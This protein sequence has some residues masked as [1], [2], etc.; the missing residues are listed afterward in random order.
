MTKLL[1]SERI[2]HSLK[3]VVACLIGLLFTKFISF[4]SDIWVVVSVIVV[5]CAQ[6][7]VG[8]V[9]RKSY[10]R[11]LGTLVGCLFAVLTLLLIGTSNVAIVV[12]I[13][14]S[15]FIFSYVATS[16]ETLMY[17]GT[18]GAVTTAV[19]MLG[20]KPTVI[21]A[22]ER[23]LEISIGILIATI[24]SQFILPIHAR[25]HLRN[26]QAT[27]LEQLRDYYIAIM[28]P[29]QNLSSASHYDEI[30]DG[31]IKLLSKQRQLTKES[32]GEP[33]GR[34]FNVKQVMQILHHEIEMLRTIYFMHRITVNL[35]NMNE[36]LTLESL[37]HFNDKFL[38][39]LNSLI[40]WIQYKDKK[41]SHIHI[42][43]L[44]QLKKEIHKKFSGEENIT[45]IDGFLFLAEILVNSLLSLANVYHVPV[46]ELPTNKN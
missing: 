24:V 22:W 32:T 40:S 44:T 42:P 20:P 8:S 2:I 33:F 41:H 27:I 14:L 30:D 38:E 31:I 26:N 16:S 11:F 46:F 45:Y 13:S 18:L 34:T 12:A 35:K 43:E 19:I 1:D 7:Y 28:D 6:I 10:L 21:F 17:A 39:S 29:K 5:M 15:S 23:F 36:F 25:K 4:S 37:H 3:T 9:I